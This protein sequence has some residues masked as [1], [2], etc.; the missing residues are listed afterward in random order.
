VGK[1]VGG[2]GASR[3][4]G[5]VFHLSCIV[6]WEEGCGRVDDESGAGRGLLPGGGM[7]IVEVRG[8]RRQSLRGVGERG[9]VLGRGGGD[10]EGCSL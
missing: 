4:Y 1:L 9:G 8:N 5:L 6:V 10:K 7:R 2:A 3:S